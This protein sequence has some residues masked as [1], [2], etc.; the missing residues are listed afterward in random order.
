MLEEVVIA[1][2]RSS[3][4]PFGA[5]CASPE[6]FPNRRHQPLHSG[7]YDFPPG[8]EGFSPPDRP[9]FISYPLR[10]IAP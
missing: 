3:Y 5:G 4:T 7:R 10:G 2:E 6:L 1:G 8:V 9:A